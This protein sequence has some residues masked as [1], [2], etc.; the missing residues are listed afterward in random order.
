MT[1]DINKVVFIL[2]IGRSGSTMLD[3]MLGSHSQGF[4]LGEISKLP[5]I[6]GRQPTPAALCPSSSFWPDHFSQEDTQRLAIGL[7]GHRLHPQIPLKLERWVRELLHQDDILNPYTLLHKRI[8]KSLLVDSSKYPDWVAR[9]LDAR[10]FRKGPMQGYVIHAVRDGRA[11]LNSYLRAYPDITIETVSQRWLANLEKCER[12]YETL[13]SHRCLQMQYEALATEPT[14]IMQDVCSF[15][16]I[17]FEP[18]MLEYWQHDHHY[19]AG[20]RSARALIARYRNQPV[21]SNT[22]EVH[23]DYY[24]KMDLT[25]KLDQRWRQELQA[26]QLDQFHAIVGDRNKPFEWN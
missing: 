8:G 24:A 12:L 22:Q 10:E 20:S 11:V 7:S 17:P 6:F 4:S 3:L 13:P 18:A 14:K 16:E 25:I 2:G 9:R 5:E 21:P 23:G 26:E 15:L 19:I 1:T